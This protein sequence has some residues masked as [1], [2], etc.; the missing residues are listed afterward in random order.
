MEGG[1]V[2][3]DGRGRMRGDRRLVLVAG[4]GAFLAVD[5]LCRT[6]SGSFLHSKRMKKQGSVTLAPLIRGQTSLRRSK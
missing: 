4:E 1:E 6:E 5:S 2:G 3:E